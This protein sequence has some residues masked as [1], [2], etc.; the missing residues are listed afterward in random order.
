MAEINIDL[1]KFKNNIRD[2]CRPNRFN[3]HI[4]KHEWEK[5]YQYLVQGASLP[6]R[7]IGDITLNWN[8]MQYKIPGDPT[9]DDFSLTFLND[10][11]F[12]IKQF[13][14]DWFD[15]IAEKEDN[16]RCTPEEAQFNIKVK[17]L[18]G[19]GDIMA[20]YEFHHCY[21]KQMDSIE[22]SH[23]TSDSVE[24]LVITFSYS[25]YTYDI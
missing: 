7:T 3:V 13:F 5:E 11:D 9:F 15:L 21:P 2:L 10:I 6:S 4:D 17:Q 24:N 12:N 19:Q 25:Y 1:E 23:E 14:E 22:L 20:E 18:D 16:T 8:G